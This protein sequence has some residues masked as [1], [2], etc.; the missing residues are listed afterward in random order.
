MRVFY[1]LL[2]GNEQV[3]DE[4]WAPPHGYWFVTSS[5]LIPVVIGLW[6]ALGSCLRTSLTC[7]YDKWKMAVRIVILCMRLLLWAQVTGS[8][9]TSP[10][11]ASSWPLVSCSPDNSLTFKDITCSHFCTTSPLPASCFFHSSSCP[12]CDNSWHHSWI[13]IACYGTVSL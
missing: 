2:C 10:S 7:M 11:A 13:S 12:Y 8:A 6:R 1:M 4:L 5:G 9:R 3:C